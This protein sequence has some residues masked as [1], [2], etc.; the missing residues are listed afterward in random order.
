MPKQR[1][2]KEDHT[3]IEARVESYEASLDASINSYAFGPQ[4]AWRLD[5]DDPVFRFNSNLSVIA[6][7]NYPEKRVGEEYE[8]TFHGDEAPSKHLGLTLGDIHVRDEHGARQYRRYRGNEIPVNEPPKGLG[9]LE[10]VRGEPR[11]HGWLTTTPRFV[12][13]ALILL[14]QSRPLFLHIHE[15]KEGRSRWIRN[16]SFQTAASN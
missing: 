16:I 10:K 15:H 7:L 3:Y 13:D 9:L 12:T 8:I 1:K 4:Y 11:W 14:E 2:R 6:I 5:E